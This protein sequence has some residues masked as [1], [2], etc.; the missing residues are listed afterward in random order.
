MI[1]ARP[2][3]NG[4]T[5]RDFELAANELHYALRAVDDAIARIQTDVVHG[6]NYLQ[7]GVDG[8]RAD[9]ERLDAA[10]AS[11]ADLYDLVREILDAAAA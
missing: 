7:A 9:T 6:R 4:N 5:A 11:R 3:I 10:R 1:H 8:H 2:N